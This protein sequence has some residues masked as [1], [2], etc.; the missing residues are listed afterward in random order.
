MGFAKVTVKRIDPHGVHVLAIEMFLTSLKASVDR[1][2]QYV[3]L[4]PSLGVLAQL[5]GHTAHWVTLW[6]SFL[7]TGIDQLTGAAFGYVIESLVSIKGSPY[8]ATPPI[9][10]DIAFQV[11]KG[12]TRPDIVLTHNGAEV[13]WFDLTASDSPLHIFTQKVGWDKQTNVAEITYPST[14]I[15]TLNRVS[16]GITSDFDA[17]EIDREIRFQKYY[18]RELRRRFKEMGLNLKTLFRGKKPSQ[19]EA[20]GDLACRV[21]TKLNLKARGPF[22]DMDLDDT[23]VTAILYALGLNPTTYGF[24]N[25]VSQSVGEHLLKIMLNIPNVVAPRQTVPLL[26]GG[27]GSSLQSLPPMPQPFQQSSQALVTVQ[28]PFTFHFNQQSP[29]SLSSLLGSS[30]NNPFGSFSSPF[31]FSSSGFSQQSGSSQALTTSRTSRFGR[32]ADRNPDHSRR[33]WIKRPSRFAIGSLQNCTIQI[34]VSDLL[35]QGITFDRISRAA[36]RFIDPQTGQRRIIAYARPGFRVTNRSRPLVRFSSNQSGPALGGPTP[37][38]NV[39]LILPTS[40]TTP[41]QQL[42]LLFGNNQGVSIGSATVEDAVVEYE[43]DQSF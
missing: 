23:Q 9:G 41:S 38:F 35:N 34:L 2:F 15:S 11:V 22:K 37:Q 8:R 21:W 16:T 42:G 40:P 39:P 20:N 7:V 5:D 33:P 14:K 28:Q 30:N 10:Y 6:N 26:L 3:M 31:S 29:P 32:G 25:S 24:Y 17:G 19:R 27:F 4:N 1:A 13:A 43:D 36:V 12:M 18:E